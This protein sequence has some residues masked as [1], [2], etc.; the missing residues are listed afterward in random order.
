M[1]TLER[2]YNIPLRK[3]FSKAPKWN[4]SKRAIRSLRS[5]LQKH[6]KSE[7]VRI[8]TG[9]NNAVWER[10]IKNPPHHVKVTAIKDDEG[11]VRAQLFGFKAK[12]EKK[13]ETKEK[14]KTEEKKIEKETKAPKKET[15][16]EEKKIEK[17][18]LPKTVGEK[19]PEPVK[20]EEAK[21]QETKT[22]EKAE[23]KKEA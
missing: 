16:T 12:E 21:E 9:V 20:K 10:G 13:T 8:G 1:A 7:D 2:T 11:V 23:T 18:E 19:T 15:P 17:K 3:D 5:F 14:P 22:E 4:R 6:M